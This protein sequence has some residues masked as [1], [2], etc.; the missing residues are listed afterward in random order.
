[1]ENLVKDSKW[2]KGLRH[3]IDAWRVLNRHAKEYIRIALW[4]SEDCPDLDSI[5]EVV[6]DGKFNRPPYP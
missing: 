1:M 5:W 6:L 4:K 2:E 3:E